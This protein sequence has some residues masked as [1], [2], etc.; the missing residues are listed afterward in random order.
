M[1]AV[2]DGMLRGFWYLAAAGKSVRRG[3]TVPVRLLGEDLLLGRRADGAVFAVGDSCPH[4]GMPMR[5]GSFDGESLRCCYHGWVFRST[6]G[7]CTEIPSLAP[8][9]GTDPARFRLRTRPAREVQGN[10]WVF[11]GDGEPGPV[12]EVRPAASSIEAVL[13]PR[14]SGRRKVPNSSI[15]AGCR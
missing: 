12:P 8:G 2:T 15:H 13:R 14:R 1:D 9:D 7:C 5:H 10:I 11:A 4:R 6:D 3:R